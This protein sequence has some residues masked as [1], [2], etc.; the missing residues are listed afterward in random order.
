MLA[1]DARS[2]IP[3]AVCKIRPAF[4]FLKKETN[5]GRMFRCDPAYDEFLNFWPGEDRV[6]IPYEKIDLVSALNQ[7]F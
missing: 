1:V 2:G 6:V 5:L 7:I 4:R 3:I